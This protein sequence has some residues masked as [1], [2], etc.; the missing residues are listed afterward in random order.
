MTMSA[1]VRLAKQGDARAI[2]QLINQQL[3][4]RGI[5]AQASREGACLH[6]LLEAR[7]AV[8]PQQ[9]VVGYLKQA[10]ERLSAVSIDEAK[11]YARRH[12]VEELGWQE[13]IS[14]L[15][16]SERRALR[17]RRRSIFR[18]CFRIWAHWQAIAFGVSFVFL[19]VLAAIALMLMVIVGDLGREVLTFGPQVAMVAVAALFFWGLILGD[20]QTEVLLQR[21]RRATLWK[22]STAI[23]LPMGLA[24]GVGVW[25][26]GQASILRLLGVLPFSLDQSV[27]WGLVMPFAA[28]FSGF[29]VLGLLQWLSVH[30]QLKQSFRWLGSATLGGALSA[31]I[32]A[33]GSRVLAQVL[34]KYWN[35]GDADEVRVAL[36]VVICTFLVWFSYHA[37]TGVT[38]ARMLHRRPMV[39]FPRR[40]GLVR[41]GISRRAAP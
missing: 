34:M 10:L 31:A 28:G 13:D 25:F 12:G 21:L 20:A 41:R 11:V 18:R 17:R 14:L 30:R 15:P 27:F 7:K 9:T 24:T 29:F 40:R 3:E 6:I 5:T 2:T 19:I 32:A 8:P 4:P 37:I 1:T 22:W 23:G 39:R 36:T 33:L 35:L 16:A 38:I 26:Y